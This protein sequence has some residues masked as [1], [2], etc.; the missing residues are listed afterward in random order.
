MVTFFRY[1]PKAELQA[2]PTRSRRSRVSPS[3]SDVGLSLQQLAR[4]AIYNA[5]N[6]VVSDFNPD[7]KE[8]TRILE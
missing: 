7:R 6:V 5:L 3:I 1:V 4:S 2:Q 8:V